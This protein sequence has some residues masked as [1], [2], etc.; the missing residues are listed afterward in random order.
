VATSHVIEIEAAGQIR[1]LAYVRELWSCR[2][3]LYLLICRDVSVRYRQAAAGALWALFKPLFSVLVLSVALGPFVRSQ[4]LGGLPYWLYVWAGLLGW[5]FFADGLSRAVGSLVNQ[6]STIRKVYFPRVLIPIAAL[7][8]G[9]ADLFW[10]AALLSV[11]AV[12]FGCRPGVRYLAL[13]IFIALAALM[14]LGLGLWLGAWNVRRR[15]VGH[16]TPFLINL[17][18]FCTPAAFYRPAGGAF[19]RLLDLNPLSQV[20]LGFRWVFLNQPYQGSALGPAFV[21]ALLILVGGLA[22]FHR[23]ERSFADFV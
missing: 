14:A 9:L 15:D 6:S 10:P 21:L 18:F 11:L 7:G 20:V 17:G 2:E 16:I 4:D 22:Y 3:L 5:N 1:P 19:S 23:S 12:G 8:V 13:P